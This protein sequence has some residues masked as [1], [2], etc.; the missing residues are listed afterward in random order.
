MVCR[1][2]LIAVEK[3][4]DDRLHTPIA[5]DRRLVRRFGRGV[6]RLRQVLLTRR[7]PLPRGVAENHIQCPLRKFHRD[8]SGKVVLIPA[9][10]TNAKAKVAVI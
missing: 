2:Q 3:E 1:A 5:E 4:S 10:G 9:N 6:L 8:T 7:F